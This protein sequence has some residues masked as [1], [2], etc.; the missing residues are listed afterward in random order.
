MPFVSI[1]FSK[2]YVFKIPAEEIVFPF[3]KSRQ[4][5]QSFRPKQPYFRRCKEWLLDASRVLGE[6]LYRLA[7]P[8][9]FSPR[10]MTS[11]RDKVIGDLGVSVLAPSSKA[12]ARI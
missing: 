6:S 10:A 4:R 11:A 12:L 7:A 2:S 8:R 1:W 9:S 3:K 5:P